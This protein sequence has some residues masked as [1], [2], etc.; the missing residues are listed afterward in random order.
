[1]KQTEDTIWKTSKTASNPAG[2]GWHVIANTQCQ[3]PYC[4]TK[5]TKQSKQDDDNP[6]Q[7]QLD[8]ED[9]KKLQKFRV[10]PDFV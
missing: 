9:A 6:D 7:I 2:H 10:A 5:L 4:G 3:C 8:E 1:M